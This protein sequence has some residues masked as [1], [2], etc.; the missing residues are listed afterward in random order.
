MKSLKSLIGFV[1]VLSMVLVGSFAAKASCVNCGTG[2]SECTRVVVGTT[3]HIFYG[4][5]TD[6]Q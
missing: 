4:E 6:C 5:K 1:C 2:T 3:T